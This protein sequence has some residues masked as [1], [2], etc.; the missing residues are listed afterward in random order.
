M[1]VKKLGRIPDG[2]GWKA[3]GRGKGNRDRKHKVGFD[4]V[5]SM[6][7]DHS[8]LA[9]SEI[10]PDETGRHLRGVPAP[11]RRS[12]SPPTGSPA[13][14]EVITDNHMSYKRSRDVHDAIATLG[15]KHLFIKPHC[16]GRTAKSNASTAPWPLMGLPPP[17][18]TNAAEPPPCPGSRTTT[19]L[20]ATRGRVN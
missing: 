17:Y 4:Y 13:S 9:Y 8:R 10:L 14:S 2:G 6:V 19:L 20:D 15:A 11:R 1:D 7:D 16:P 12:T 5:H 18:L 3:H